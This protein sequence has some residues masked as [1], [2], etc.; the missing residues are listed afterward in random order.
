[1]AQPALFAI[2]VALYRLLEAWGVRPDYLA[3]HSIGELAAAHVA[4]VWSLPDAAVLVAARGRLMQA[5]PPGGGMTAIRATETQVQAHL[6]DGVEVAAVNAPDGVVISGREDAVAQVAAQFDRVRSLP[7]SHAFHSVL[8]DPMLAEFEDIA[9]SV[10]YRPPAVP[11]VSNLTGEMADPEQLC[12]PA[13]WVRHVRQAVRFHDGVQTLRGHGV[14]TFLEIGPD[15]ALTATA[16]P[17]DDAEFIAVQRRDRDQPRQLLTALA[18]LHT[19][20]VPVDWA[21]LFPGAQRVDLPTYAFQ[22]QRFWLDSVTAPADP[23]AAGQ[24]NAD[25]P[26]LA[27]MVALP[28]SDGVAWTGR[29]SLDTHPWLADHTVTG[30]VLLPGTAFVEL[31]LFAGEQ[32]GCPTIEELTLHH[33]LVLSPDQGAAIQVTVA[34]PDE[35]GHRTVEVHSRPEGSADSL[36][37]V[38][39]TGTVGLNTVEVR[40]GAGVWP[41]EGAVA[42]PVQEFYDRLADQGLAYGPSFQ[43]LQT[44]WRR[45]GEVFAEIAVPGLE[46]GGYG[47]HPALL[48]AALHTAF[49]HTNTNTDT[50][51]D[52]TDTGTSTGSGLGVAV[53]FSWSGIGLH[54]AGATALRVH[55]PDP[56]TL[57]I[58]DTTGAPVA[59]VTTVTTRPLTTGPAAATRNS[60][61][62]VGWEPVAVPAAAA[63]AAGG[64]D[65]VVLESVPGTAPQDVRAATHRALE[66]LQGWLSADH[67][68]G[69][70]LVVTTRG[71]VAARPDDAVTDLAGAAVWGLCRA[72]QEEN[73]DRI[74]LVDLDSADASLEPAFASDEPQLALR[75]DSLLAPRLVRPETADSGGKDA[76]DAGGAVLVT[77]GTGGLGGLVARH[78]VAEHGVRRLVLASRR[79][80]DA[81]GAAGLVAELAELGAQARVVACDV[82]DRSALAGLVASVCADGG[83][84]A[85]VHAAG[86]LDDGVVSS[87]TAE[88][89]DGVLAPKVDAAWHLHEL[90]REL[91]LS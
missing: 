9:A 16:D 75:G 90:T 42:V 36:W 78:L 84:G 68:A 73:P 82:T 25:H 31:A 5:L 56:Q 62:R 7:V 48:D 57:H 71:A 50:G 80:M 18:D 17:G 1:W 74:V 64:A 3:G 41:P 87:L 52:S 38:H 70:R 45:G 2:E 4:G 30:T 32:V 72:A 39:A 15:A 49:L 66:V 81:D 55:L 43:G 6:V 58:T 89:L 29:V 24:Q 88:R 59:T 47:I 22:R 26:L 12:T 34:G 11:I 69:S 20:G 23:A 28:G 44:A 46:V 35:A 63:V 79:G 76:W 53:P 83:L 65:V 60:L 13:Y 54:A 86:I 37:T 61:F 51:T 77:G 91:D 40:A 8:M 27:A 33:P 85:V 19:R 21:A 10:S 14:T 67:P